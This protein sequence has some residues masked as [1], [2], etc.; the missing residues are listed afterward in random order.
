MT[1]GAGDEASI[2]L[3]LGDLK[4]DFAHEFT[5]AEAVPGE[6]RFWILDFARR[7]WAGMVNGGPFPQQIADLG[8]AILYY[9]SIFGHIQRRSLEL[10]TS[11]RCS[12]DVCGC[13]A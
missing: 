6:R 10:K 11:L 3:V 1:E 9:P 12:G 13:V 5:I 2:R 8:E 4:H 7:R